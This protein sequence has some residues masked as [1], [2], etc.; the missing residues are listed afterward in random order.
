MTYKR[1]DKIW[2]IKKEWKVAGAGG[3]KFLKKRGKP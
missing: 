2:D 3:R 1:C